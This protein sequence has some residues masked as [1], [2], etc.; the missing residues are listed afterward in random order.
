MDNA[1]IAAMEKLR[2]GGDLKLRVEATLITDRLKSLNPP[3]TK[4]PSAWAYVEC[5]VLHLAEDM[6]IPRD[7]WISIVLPQVG[8]GVVHVLEFPAAPLEA[9]MELKGSFDAMKQAQ[10]RHR[11]GMYDDAVGKCRVALDPFFELIEKPDDK[12]VV[13]R[14]PRLQ[15]SWETK[16][17]EATYGW[18]NGAFGAIKEAGNKNHHTAQAHYDQAESQMILVITAAVLSFVAR[19]TRKE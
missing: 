15:K 3:G 14:I 2:N 9:C 17:G 13:R 19:T 11:I 6:T 16:L 10:E 18:L 8:Y 7:V 1:R 12:G 5:L 4:Y